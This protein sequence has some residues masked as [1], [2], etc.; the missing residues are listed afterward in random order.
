VV[1]NEKK[2]EREEEGEGETNFIYARAQIIFILSFK[3]LTLDIK[4]L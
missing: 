1:R 4:I 3:Y 2:S